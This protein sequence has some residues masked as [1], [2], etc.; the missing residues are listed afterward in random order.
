MPASTDPLDGNVVVSAQEHRDG[1][2]TGENIRLGTLLLHT[3]GY[4]ILHGAV[5]ERLVVELQSTFRQ[6]YQDCLQQT[7]VA[8]SIVFWERGA[9]FRI[10]PK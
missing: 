7:P 6:L 10:F 3:R 4:V 1:G 8:G 2:L 9:R 5:P